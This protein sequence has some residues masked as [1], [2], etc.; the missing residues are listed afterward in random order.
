MKQNKYS[1][2]PETLIVLVAVGLVA[3]YNL[4]FW[5]KVFVAAHPA[6]LSG[7]LFLGAAMLLLVAAFSL[8][9]SLLPW[10]WV[11]RPLLTLVLPLAALTTYFMNQYGVAI[12][13][14]MILNV[15]ETDRSEVWQLVSLPMLLYFLAL[16]VLP[17]VLLW[18]APLR[19]QAWWPSLRTRAVAL[20]A[21]LLV[22][23]LV[24]GSFYQSFA[25]LL[26]NNREL[27]YYLVPN[28]FLNGT[29]HYF[30]DH[31]E[32]PVELKPIGTDAHRALTVQQRPRK[33]LVV[34][35]VGE[36]ARAHNFSLN[37]YARDTNPELR[38]H[39]DI[40]NFRNARSCGTET[41]VSLPCMLSVLSHDDYSLNAARAQ[42]NLLDVVQRA[43]VKVLWVENQSG[44]KRTC[45]RVQRI[46]TTN[47]QL[48]GLCTKDEC[49]D[50]ILVEQLKKYLQTATQDT[51]VVLHQM[52]SHGPAY[53]LRYPPAF[54]KFTPVCK[55]NLLDKCSAE[56]I[57]N[58]Y[59]NTILYTDHVLASL[60]DT[61]KGYGNKWDTAML[62]M[63]DH[64]ESLGE[65]GL[66]LH[67][68]PYMLAP[69]L[70]KRVP[71][72]TWLS[73]EFQQDNGIR[74]DCVAQ[75]Q[76]A[77]I[78]HDNLFHSVLGLL[79]IQTS[80]YQPALDLYGRCRHPLVTAGRQ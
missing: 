52:G 62:Y 4:A 26:R 39:G 46:D 22:I 23:G 41:A 14:R 25:S 32:V 68:A 51:L 64:G 44:C 15:F 38:R 77:P 7:A 76:D 67:G 11:T 1:W 30:S 59:D 56:Q 6:G 16:G 27:R 69:D 79:D 61:L 12:D 24:A 34:L 70:Q 65:Y 5:K 29:K 21:S 43:G 54:E 78:S 28:N 48:P 19:P 37:G 8:V 35:V 60:I 36:T 80:I 2:R 33:T 49:H 74:R 31:S 63:S 71:A 73:P 18:K 42:E 20:V 57:T 13:D 40:V 45:D 55:T 3:F 72:I 47:L 53:Y 58:T 66:Y 50:E 17:V 75:E 9:L 10:R